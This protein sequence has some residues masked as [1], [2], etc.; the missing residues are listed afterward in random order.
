MVCS[1]CRELGYPER[2]RDHNARTCRYEAGPK[3]PA[4]C[5]RG[6]DGGMVCGWDV[7]V[8]ARDVQAEARRQRA[9][10]R[11]A[12]KDKHVAVLTGRHG[13]PG[14]RGNDTLSCTRDGVCDRAFF[15]EDRRLEQSMSRVKVHDMGSE[16]GVRRGR[17]ALQNKEAR[18]ILGWCHGQ[19]HDAFQKNPGKKPAARAHRDADVD[20]LSSMLARM[21]S[22][23]GG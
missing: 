8:D 16:S 14:A 20:D 7:P 3:G 15:D 9:V 19:Q 5:V 1:I 6:R 2:G 22:S 17:E 21:Q 13:G 4:K 23:Y 12:G 10:A 18:V 11:A